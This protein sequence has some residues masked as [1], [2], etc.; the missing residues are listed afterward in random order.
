MIFI[1]DGT[2]DFFDVDYKIEMAGS[3][4]TQIDNLFGPRTDSDH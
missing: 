3:F 1:V 4:C 2:G